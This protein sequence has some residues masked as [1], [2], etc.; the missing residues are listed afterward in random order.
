MTVQ[1]TLPE[2]TPLFHKFMA[3]YGDEHN[4]INRRVW[5]PVPWMVDVLTEGRER[6]ILEWCFETWGPESHMGSEGKW[7]RGGAT[8]YGWT[9]FGFSTRKIMD[10][11][12]A[13][14]PSPAERPR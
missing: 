11:F 4:G 14:W 7:H 13:R 1:T 2:G 10:E 5:S 9:W 6:D 12:V 8:I 3:E